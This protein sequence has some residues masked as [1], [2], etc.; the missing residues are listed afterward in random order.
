LAD[1]IDAGKHPDLKGIVAAFV[2]RRSF[3]MEVRN[4]GQVSGL[5]V[6]GA[7]SA[8]SHFTIK[9]EAGYIQE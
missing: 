6:P 5:E 4:W 9:N 7:L 3:I 1:E 8:A 2:E